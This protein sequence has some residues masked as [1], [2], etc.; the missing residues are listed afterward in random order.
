[1]VRRNFGRRETGCRDDGDPGIGPLFWL[2]SY[3]LPPRSRRLAT[4]HSNFYPVICCHFGTAM[5]AWAGWDAKSVCRRRLAGT[6]IN[7]CIVQR[8]E[9][10]NIYVYHQRSCCMVDGFRSSVVQT[11]RRR[12]RTLLSPLWHLQAK[13][14]EGALSDADVGESSP[15]GARLEWDKASTSSLSEMSVACLQD[16]IMQM[17]ETHYRLGPL[18]GHTP[19]LTLP[20]THARSLTLA[21]TFS[22]TSSYTHSHTIFVPSLAPSLFHSLILI[23]TYFHILSRTHSH[24]CSLSLSLTHTYC[25]THPLTHS[26]TYSLIHTST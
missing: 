1:M 14:T 16:R 22:R 17:E 5:E 21:L 25:L 8:Y 12:T 4:W 11:P 6:V 20:L 3:G 15:G 2:R 18:H 19:T 9:K 26:F 10:W 23:L 13:S 24:T 7:L